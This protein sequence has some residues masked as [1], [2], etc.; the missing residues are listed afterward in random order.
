VAREMGPLL[1]LGTSLAAS[2]LLGLF[3]G[4]W[5]DAHWGRD[6]LFTILGAMAG[7]AAGMYQFVRTVMSKKP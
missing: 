7:L 5:A 4:R 2:V 3:L 1:G 6:P